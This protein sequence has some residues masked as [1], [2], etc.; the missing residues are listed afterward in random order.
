MASER[1][2]LPCQNVLPPRNKALLRLNAIDPVI[3]VVRGQR[4]ILDSDLA[5][6]YG[7]T[8]KR[9]NE[10]VNGTVKGFRMTSCFV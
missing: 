10:Q 5:R 1:N 6:I 4:V 9:L 8:T 3:H 7:V 2:E